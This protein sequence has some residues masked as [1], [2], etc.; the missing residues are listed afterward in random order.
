MQPSIWWVLAG[1]AFMVVEMAAATFFLIWFGVGAF[2][3][4][5][6]SLFVKTPWA[7]Y[8]FFAVSSVLLVVVSRRWTQRLS[9]PSARAANMDAL[10]GQEGLVIEL[11]DGAKGCVVI[12]VAGETWRAETE[13][14]SPLKQGQNVTVKAAKGNILILKSRT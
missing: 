4:A 14:A 5:I 12:K 11:L 10:A 7:Q 9:G 2:L 8:T 3:T 13:D 1:V 6:F